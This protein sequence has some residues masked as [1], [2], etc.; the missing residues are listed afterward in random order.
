MIQK[1]FKLTVDDLTGEYWY[2]DDIIVYAE[3]HGEAKSKGLVEFDGAEV[4]DY[5]AFR[6]RRDVKFTDIKAR[7]IKKYDK[8]LYEGKLLTQEEIKSKEWEK[9][10]DEEARLIWEN[11][12][13]GIA[14]VWAECYGSYWGFNKCGYSSTLEN[15]GKYSTKEAYEIVKGNC[16]SR[17]EKV[18][19]ID[20]EDYNKKIEDKIT[21]LSE[22]YLK[23]LED[24]KK[25]KL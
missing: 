17:G 12:P 15:A 1:A 10:R 4:E 11:N 8:T 22:R 23:E 9:N 21:E 18:I 14:V 2:Y 3:T 6:D 24:L 13:Q 5:K 20:K 16:H 19:L 7:R 25:C